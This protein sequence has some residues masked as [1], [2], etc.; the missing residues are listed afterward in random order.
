MEGVYMMSSVCGICGC[1][2]EEVTKNGGAHTDCLR[3]KYGNWYQ[4]GYQRLIDGWW[5]LMAK[6]FD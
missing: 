2:D 4:K 1:A 3:R 5:W 6:L